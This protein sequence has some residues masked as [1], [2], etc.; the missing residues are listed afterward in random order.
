MREDVKERGVTITIL[1][2]GVTDTDFFNKADMESAKSVAE[3]SKADPAEVAQ[4]GYDALMAGKDKVVSGLM[5]KVQAAMSNLLPDSL[6]ASYMHK[7][8]A[9]VDGKER[10]Q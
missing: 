5:N 7:Q 1:E 6:V 3:G 4:G 2:P 9:P 8:A 10:S